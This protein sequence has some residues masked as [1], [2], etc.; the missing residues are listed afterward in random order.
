[1]RSLVITKEALEFVRGL[2]AKHF[3]QVMNKV[4]SLLTLPSP[5]D[6]SALKGFT[7][8]FRAD[9]G[10]HRIVYKFDDKTVSVLV[11]DKRNDDEVYK[12]LSR[13]NL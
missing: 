4:L 10:E 7:D 9:I 6:S 11:V 5:T 13:K 2:E 12:K 1:V 3:K 8:L